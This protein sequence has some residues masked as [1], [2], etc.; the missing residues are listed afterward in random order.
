VA[1]V[2][3]SEARSPLVRGPEAEV[4]DQDLVVR[5]LAGLPPRMRAVLVLRFLDDLTEA[6]TAVALR[7]GVGTV[8]SQTSRGLTR[9][10]ELPWS[11]AAGA[12]RP[13]GGS[14]SPPA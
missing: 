12:G 13:A 11:R 2:P 5:A 4:V 8:K 6:D 10:R 14:P 3:L 9:L 7:C 1:E